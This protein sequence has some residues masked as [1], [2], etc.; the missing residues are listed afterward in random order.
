MVIEEALPGE[1]CDQLLAEMAPF[2]D[3][4][5]HGLHGLG[6]TRRCV[7]HRH[8]PDPHAPSAQCSD[9]RG[10]GQGALVA[11]SPTSHKMISHPAVLSLVNS[12]LGEQQL[13]GDAVRIGGHKGKGDTEKGFA[14]P[15]QLHLTQII[16]VGP[17][18]GTD[19]F[20]H[21]FGA[22]NGDPTV[23]NLHKANGMW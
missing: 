7:R 6:G 14:Y 19:A 2:L 10:L 4:T 18:G 21:Q 23:T 13:R 16:D 3:A 8:P 1:D 20:P 5:P 11:R 12:V 17:G 22:S 15:W 9:A